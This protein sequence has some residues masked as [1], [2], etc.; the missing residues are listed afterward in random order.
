MH[1]L[2]TCWT[3]ARWQDCVSQALST[4]AFGVCWW[5]VAHHVTHGMYLVR[6]QP[7]KPLLHNICCPSL[8]CL[9]SKI[10]FW[11]ARP[12]PRHTQDMN[13]CAKGLLNP[14][15]PNT[16]PWQ[17]CMFQD[18]PPRPEHP[19]SWPT[20]DTGRNW[21]WSLTGDTICYTPQQIHK[22]LICKFYL[23]AVLHKKKSKKWSREFSYLKMTECF[24][25][26]LVL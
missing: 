4:K 1:V 21:E 17:D 11:E 5:P 2:M 7:K 12:H 9:A 8:V 15:Q 19:G 18:F 3:Q 24:S 26:F 14:S 13:A 16:N 6:P 23:G 20:R 10:W 22:K 25:R